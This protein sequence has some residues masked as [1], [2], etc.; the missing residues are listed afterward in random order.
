VAAIGE[1]WQALWRFRPDVCHAFLGW[2]TMFGIPGA[3]IGR[4]PVRIAGRRGLPSG[5]RLEPHWLATR[6]LS[7]LCSHAIVANSRA[8]ALAVGRAEPAARRKLH[9]IPN[10]VDMPV[11][12]ANVA[13]QPAEGLMVANLIDYKGHR[14][15][16]EALSQLPNPPVVRLVGDGRER[17]ALT[18]LVSAR[19]LAHAVTFEGAIPRAREL[20]ARAQFG[21]LASH[22]EGMPNAILEAMSYGVPVIATA[23]GGVPELVRDGVDGL[24]VPSNSPAQ[25]AAAIARLAGDAALR[26][27]LGASARSRAR[28]FSWTRCVTAHEDLYYGLMN[29]KHKDPG[30]SRFLGVSKG[31]TE[32]AGP[33]EATR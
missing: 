25:L 33:V 32:F 26:L 28:E 3:A 11:A 23:V 27:N 8:V 31:P 15:L 2:A 17:R 22:E 5:P 12:V 14:D 18:A 19:G 24:L 16:I 6:R 21:V 13:A 10:G 30:R 9:V 7:V 20:F 4:I 29:D 1:F